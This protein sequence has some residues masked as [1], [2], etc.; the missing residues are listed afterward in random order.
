MQ[1]RKYYYTSTRIGSRIS[2][3]RRILIL[4]HV[5]EKL[6][7]IKYFHL[8]IITI[9]VFPICVYIVSTNKQVKQINQIND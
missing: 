2:G 6:R 5:L 3:T 4:G 8:H 7:Y 1:P 9:N